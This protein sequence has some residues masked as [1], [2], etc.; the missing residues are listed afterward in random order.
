MFNRET[1]KSRGFGFVV[2]ENEQSVDLILN[3]RDHMIDGKLV[4]NFSIFHSDGLTSHRV[5]LIG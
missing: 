4:P 2:F 3:E 5:C 1:N